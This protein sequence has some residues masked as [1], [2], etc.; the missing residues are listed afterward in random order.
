[1]ERFD[2]SRIQTDHILDMPL[3]R[4]TALE[5]RRLEEER[6][7]LKDSI[8]NFQ[9]L[10]KSEKRQRT[11]VLDELGDAVERFGRPRR[12][13]IVDLEDVPAF[14]P[15][16]VVEELVEEP[17]VVTL[18]SSGQ[19]GRFPLEGARRATPG[20]HDV[21]VT[22][23]LTQTTATISAVTSEGRVL[24]SLAAELADG[25]GRG[26]GA[27]ADQV[28]GTNRGE[29]ILTT[30]ADGTEHLVLVTAA[31]TVKRLTPNEVQTTK[32]GK[33]IIKL[34]SG[35]RVAAAFCVP[36]G[37]D[38]VISASDGQVLRTPVAGISVQGRGASGVTGMKLRNG[39]TV[40]AA[41]P[42][43]GDDLLVTVTNDGAAKATPLA[44]FESRGRGGIGIRAT[45]IPDGI[46]VTVAQVGT[47]AGLLAVMTSDADPAK[48]DP[49]PVP[50]VLES[51][52][53]DLVATTTERQILALGPARW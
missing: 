7:G 20:R 40:V 31:G 45:K 5:T 14:E 44:E 36:E 50:L 46:S 48:A 33:S 32:T 6:D 4:L 13:E 19:I 16:E 3:K 23:V 1:M 43:L 38:V 26:R 47:V 24:Q 18:S 35:D 11:L 34:K 10:L 9:A 2:L 42:A 12:T 49:K 41:G 8:A 22:S 27:S 51:T 53:R 28:F 25:T 37:V 30:V 29:V 17:C 52:K 39:A 21:L 15:T